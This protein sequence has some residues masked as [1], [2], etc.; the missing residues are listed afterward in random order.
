[1][2]KAKGDSQYRSLH[3]TLLKRVRCRVPTAELAEDITQEAMLR[4]WRASKTG[5][6]KSAIAL[7]RTIADNLVIDFYR[8]RAFASEVEV[9][10]TLVAFHP[11]PEQAAISSE[12]VRQFRDC[13]QDM[14]P[15]RR[16]VFLR[17]R[18]HGQACAQIAQDLGLTPRAVE[19][20]ISRALRDL[21]KVINDVHHD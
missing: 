8:R 20:H 21:A 11:S 6:I 13:L 7:G 16:D 19:A 10:D 9:E 4:V 14:P 18:F 3:Q 12:R 5:E 1:M 17:R 15:L 2:L